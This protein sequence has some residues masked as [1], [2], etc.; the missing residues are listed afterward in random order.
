MPIQIHSCLVETGGLQLVEVLGELVEVLRR[1]LSQP[2][3][4]LFLA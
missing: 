3:I 2:L 1:E 4:D